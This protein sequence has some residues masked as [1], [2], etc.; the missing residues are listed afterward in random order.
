MD[1]REQADT[2][3]RIVYARH[4]YGPS[5]EAAYT[6]STATCTTLQPA[7][8]QYLLRLLSSKWLHNLHLLT[9]DWLSPTSAT[10]L[11]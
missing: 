8:R 5:T 11:H 4:R 2:L 1:R 10:H 3:N 9:P 7:T 6:G